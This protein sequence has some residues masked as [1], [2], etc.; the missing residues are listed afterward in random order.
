MAQPTSKRGGPNRGQGR[1]PLSDGEKTVRI[2][3]TMTEAQR[4]KLKQ[5]GGSDWLRQVIDRA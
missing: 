3:L 4:D 2:N 1:K 5:L